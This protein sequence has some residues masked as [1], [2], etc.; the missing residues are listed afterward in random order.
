MTL[1]S[2]LQPASHPSRLD[3]HH[4]SLVQVGDLL[5]ATLLD[6]TLARKLG[7]VCPIPAPLRVA[8]PDQNA[9]DSEGRAS[10]AVQVRES[11]SCVMFERSLPFMRDS[12]PC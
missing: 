9:A 2:R 7:Q 4:G 6:V 12:S 1:V 3:W 11:L 10:C 8:F 5:V